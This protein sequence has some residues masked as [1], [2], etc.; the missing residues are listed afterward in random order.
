[1]GLLLFTSGKRYL[2]LQVYGDL[3]AAN[4]VSTSNPR[5]T[6]TNRSKTML[7]LKTCTTGFMAMVLAAAL[8]A[9]SKAA[10]SMTTQNTLLDR[11][12]IEDMMIDYYWAFS[13]KEGHDI[14]KYWAEDGEFNVG[15]HVAKGWA[16]IAAEYTPRETLTKDAPKFVMLL[17][18]PKIHVTGDTAVMDAIFTGYTSIDPTKAPIASEQGTDHVEFVKIAGQWKIKKRELGTYGYVPRESLM[19]K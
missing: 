3:P 13:A 5:W 8:S 15:D 12:Q 6:H 10:D 1:L 16:A 19:K 9:Q 7:T 14:K 18:N 4:V 2:Q 17:G 11:I